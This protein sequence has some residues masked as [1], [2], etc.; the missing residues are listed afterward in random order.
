VRLQHAFFSIRSLK[1][2]FSVII[3]AIDRRREASMLEANFKTE[4]FDIPPGTQRIL[5]WT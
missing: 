4:P 1:P 3:P 2:A 5:I